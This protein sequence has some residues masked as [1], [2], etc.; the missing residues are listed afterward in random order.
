M[1]ICNLFADVTQQTQEKKTIRLKDKNFVSK[2]P[3]GEKKGSTQVVGANP[4]S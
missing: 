2:T 4:T 3:A 1:T